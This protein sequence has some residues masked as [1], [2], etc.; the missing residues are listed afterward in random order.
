MDGVTD[1]WPTRQAVISA[2]Q[3]LIIQAHRQMDAAQTGDPLPDTYLDA[4]D[5]A[6]AAR[7]RYHGEVA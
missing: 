5:A 4:V 3:T 1:T 2:M 7:V 6:R